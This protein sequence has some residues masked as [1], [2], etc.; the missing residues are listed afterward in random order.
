MIQLQ[1]FQLVLIMLYIPSFSRKPGSGPPLCSKGHY[2]ESPYYRPLQSCIGGT[3]SRRWIPIEQR[4][5]WPSRANLNKNELAIY[6]K[7]LYSYYTNLEQHAGRNGT[8]LFVI[9]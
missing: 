8:S 9:Y 7:V 1:S 5:S 6:G 2:V 4:S 3:Q